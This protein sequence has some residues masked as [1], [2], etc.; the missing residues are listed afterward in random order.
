MHGRGWQ[1][2]ALGLVTMG[3]GVIGC[4]TAGPDLGLTPLVATSAPA[5]QDVSAKLGYDPAKALLPLE[6]IPPIVEMPEPREKPDRPI[7]PQALKHYLAGRDLYHQWRTAECI[8]ELEQALRYD[9]GSLE[10][11]LL[12]GR[13]A[14]RAGDQGQAQ[15]HLREAAK[16]RPDDVEC[17]YLLGRLAIE[18]KAP[19]EALRRFRLALM[20][21][22]AEP[23]RAETI[24]THLRLGEVL[25]NDGYLSAAI[26][27]LEAFEE[28]VADPR[29]KLWR[30][31]ELLTIL[32]TR[33]AVPSLVIGQAAMVLRRYDQAADAF[34][35]ALEFQPDDLRCKVRYA[36][37]LT[38]AGRRAEALRLARELALSKDNSKAGVELLGW[39]HKDGG[40]PEALADELETLLVANPDRA[41]LSILLADTLASLKK[42]QQAEQVLR[43]V[44]EE[45]PEFTIAYVRLAALLKQQDRL[46]EVI[47]TLADA[48]AAGPKTHAG[49][50]RAVSQ[51]GGDTQT[52]QRVV[53]RADAM[54]AKDA[55]NPAL[56]YVIGLI[57][58]YGDRQ[59]L[60]AQCFERTLELNASFLPAYLS[61]GRMHLNRFKWQQA[62]DVADRAAKAGQDAPAVAFLRAQ[63]YDGLDD[64][65]RATAGYQDVIKRDPKSVPAM[66]ALGELYERLGEQNRARQEYQRALKVEP[67]NTVAGERY[68]RLLLTQG[69]AK[70]A[71]E[72][73]KRFRRAGGGRDAVGR[74]L[75]VMA[76]RG[77]MEQYRHLIGQMLSQSPKD[78]LTRYDLATSY[79]S[80]RDYDRARQEVDRILEI[81]PGHQKS[82]FLMAELCRKKLDPKSAAEV[83][84]G[85]LTE[86]PNRHLWLLGLAEVCLDMQDYDRAA[87]IFEQLI[88]RSAD[89]GRR[90]AYRL[91]LIGVHVAA[92]AYDKAAAAAED[93]LKEDPKSLTARRLMVEALHEAGQDHRAIELAQQWVAE[94]T[95]E[96]KKKVKPAE[97]EAAMRESR[98]LLIAAYVSA[99]QHERALETLLRWLE[100]DPSSRAMLRQVWVALFSAK[101]YEDAAELCRSAIP[102]VR[103]PAAYRMMLAQTYMEADRFDE[104][105][106][107]LEKMPDDERNEIVTRLELMIL[108]KAKRYDEA[109]RVAKQAVARA[110]DD[111]IRLAMRRLLVLVYQ[112]AGQMDQATAELERV[113][114]DRPHE[115][116]SNN[117]LGYT[118]ADAGK[119]LDKAETMIRYALGEEPRNSAYMDSLG[120]V[121]YKK[122]AFES[123]VQWLE[124]AG[125]S[126]GGD[127][128]VIFEH[129]G[130]A[131]WRLGRKDQAKAS[132]QQAVELSLKE[133]SED[134]DP[135]D[136]ETL[137]RVGGKLDQLEQG[138]QPAVADVVGPGASTKAS[139]G[140]ATRPSPSGG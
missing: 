75:A 28:A 10:C 61:L 122:G 23:D 109:T 62:I 25:F 97:M 60:A 51:L 137:P 7:P 58:F 63:G 136:P 115:P 49:V 112:R 29:G 20:A 35:R 3:M 9:P 111:E 86:H 38:R 83:L 41:D 30:N 2:M 39:I 79:Y 65:Q 126:Q 103:R 54:L 94:E 121:L 47:R 77:N 13:A 118:W 139:K 14:L 8:E 125:R 76:S 90:A 66:V 69:E 46:E 81:A 127:D 129:L 93:W 1:C 80:T 105:L 33:R 138:R 92:R 43:G 91:R 67:G 131:Y 78:V 119:N 16:L 96:H 48:I 22:N 89:K 6:Q 53:E 5:T 11:H 110:Q 100:E 134:K 24:L 71:G 133:R 57:A 113:Y 32:S 36:Q 31:R 95:A 123:A 82:R 55:K 59:D 106:D 34:K 140:A 15:N 102:A 88:E 124:K 101:R 73:L 108:L 135:A 21:S 64:I 18:N 19:E 50:L 132:W 104:A 128:P 44:I 117:D 27:Q 42:Q 72:A 37:T 26:D 87:G 56:S 99:D 74:C 17:Q 84:S 107:S 4:K 52:V 12:L 68:I 120:W 85:L 116:G 130:D 70:E 98:S 40:R 45:Q 114:A